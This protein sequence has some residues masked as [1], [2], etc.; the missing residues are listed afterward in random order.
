MVKERNDRDKAE[1]ERIK[2]AS[3]EI[4]EKALLKELEKKEMEVEKEVEEKVFHPE[5]KPITSDQISAAFSVS[6]LPEPTTTID[7]VANEEMK[8]AGV[9]QINQTNL[10]IDVSLG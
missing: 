2:R 5:N 4:K 8:T 10:A 1:E 7:I 6:V 9:Q 3:E